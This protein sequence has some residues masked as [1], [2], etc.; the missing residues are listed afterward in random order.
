MTAVQAKVGCEPRLAYDDEKA[1]LEFL[2]GA[3]GFQEQARADCQGDGLMAWL[4][5][6]KSILMIGRSGPDRHNLY[7]PRQTG[8][9]TAEVNVAVDDI[10]AH[11]RRAATAGAVIEATL[12]NASFGQRHYRAL[13]S[14]GH[15]WHFMKPLQ[16]IRDGKPTPERL[17]PRL[18][19]SDERA[20]VDFLTRAFGFQERARIDSPPGGL[21]AWLGLGDSLVMI[22]GAGEGQRRHR[23]TMSAKPT[24]MLN[25][26]VDEIDAH[27]QR[28][29]AQGAQIVTEIENTAWGYRRYEALDPEGNRWHVMQPA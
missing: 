10:D 27:Y 26:H 21:M 5:F 23:A 6:G 25:L 16:D 22:S 15:R 1:A 18:I 12:E 19:Y 7:S 3:F 11:F 29:V 2:T 14:E 28:A 13:D 8:R 17:E 4:S 9:S 24:A 20:A